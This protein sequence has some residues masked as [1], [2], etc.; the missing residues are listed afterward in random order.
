MYYD[1]NGNRTKDVNKKMRADDHSAY[2]FNTTENKYD[3]RDRLTSVTRTGDTAGTE[4]YV[5]DANNNVISQTV[6]NVTTA[7]NYDRNRLLTAET[8]GVRSSYNY[9]PFGRL[10]TVTSGSSVIERN[11]YDGFDH[12]IEKRTKN[13][14]G[15]SVTKYTFDPMDRTTTK[16]TDAGGAKE[17]TTTF[18]YLGL[19]SD[20]LNEEV[21]GKVAKSYQ[22]SPWGQRL[23]QVTHKDDGGEEDAYY[24]YSPHTDVEQVTDEAGDAKATYGYTAYGKDNEAEFT[25]IDKPDTTDPSK[26]P[27]N[28]YRFNAKRWDQA[29]GEYDMGFRDYS[30]NLNRFLSRDSYNGAL[31]DMNLGTD[32]WNSNRYAFGGG[33]PISSVEIDG[34]ISLT[35]VWDDIKGAIKGVGKSVVKGRGNPALTIFRLFADIL[36]DASPAGSTGTESAIGDKPDYKLGLFVTPDRKVEWRP[37]DTTAPRYSG[38]CKNTGQNWVYYKPLDYY[39]R[40]SGVTACLS[41]TG[42]NYE[43]NGELVKKDVP[44][45]KIVGTSPPWPPQT[46]GFWENAP[47][48]WTLDADPKLQ[49]GHLLARQLGG[50]GDDRRNLVPMYSYANS[51]VM[52]GFENQIAASIK[53]GNTVYFHAVPNYTGDGPIPTS[54]TLQAWTTQGAQVVNTVIPNVPGP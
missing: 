6:K 52:R 3:P 32:P 10:D 28:A 7:Y 18:N 49:R 36:L 15:T 12:V 40:A 51:P 22:Y 34:H 23:S 33:N 17:K 53:A 25:G 38:D 45:T 46:P 13:G 9:D 26:E 48:G 50:V 14:T 39:G 47:K 5:H 16:T 37:G 4:T 27:Y 2:I 11:V 8:N 31:A 19:S 30:P 20:V 1:L 21:A 24:G 42:F 54:I 43:E 44:D 41:A 35:G 29:S